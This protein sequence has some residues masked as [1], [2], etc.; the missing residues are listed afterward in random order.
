[1]KVVFLDVD[2]VLNHDIS[3]EHG[4][5]LDARNVS[6]IDDLCKET[7]A[8]LVISSTW[9]INDKNFTSLKDA[10]WWLGFGAHDYRGIDRTVF[11]GYGDG[12]RHDTR[13]FEIQQ[14][15]DEHPEIT[16]YVILDDDADMLESQQDH[17]VHV[18]GSNGLT[19]SDW[20]EAAKILKEVRYR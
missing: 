16:H 19:I 4:V 11:N 7:G 14:Y 17:F 10:L 20:Y 1:M 15:L 9:R 8:K 12:N 6:L 2:G 18:N 5:Q 3:M 13:G